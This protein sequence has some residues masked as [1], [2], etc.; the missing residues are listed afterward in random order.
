MGDTIKI[1]NPLTQPV[2]TLVWDEPSGKYVEKTL[3]A[4]EVLD[5]AGKLSSLLEQQILNGALK[6]LQPA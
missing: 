2:R 5:V 3:H 4:K 1:R 6:R